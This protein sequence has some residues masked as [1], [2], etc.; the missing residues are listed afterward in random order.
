MFRRFHNVNMERLLIELL[1]NI[2][3]SLCRYGK[4]WEFED[5][6]E[7]RKP[8]ASHLTASAVKDIMSFRLVSVTFQHMS[9]PHFAKVITNTTFGMKRL[10]HLS[11]FAQ[12]R[13]G[14]MMR[15]LTL[16][17]DIYSLGF[18]PTNYNDPRGN[19]SDRCDCETCVQSGPDKITAQLSDVLRNLTR[20]EAIFVGQWLGNTLFRRLRQ[21]AAL[22]CFYGALGSAPSILKTLVLPTAVSF[23]YNYFAAN[24][25]PFV[26]LP[27]S[28]L[29]NVT[30]LEMASSCDIDCCDDDPRLCD[31]LHIFPR[32]STLSLRLPL[33]L[34][35]M[36]KQLR[37][38]T[39]RP[40][41]HLRKLKISLQ[42]MQEDCDDWTLE[43]L[44]D[45]LHAHAST[46]KSLQIGWTS[47]SWQD[48]ELELKIIKEIERTL[49]LSFL[50]VIWR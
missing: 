24:I 25:A 34:H 2:C 40:I 35:V 26:V 22:I 38:L 42:N 37:D 4:P 46:L 15:V 13:F 14:P 49:D 9:E 47:G 1:N 32:L 36:R 28:P 30:F 18:C 41:L 6:V 48:V 31:Y 19:V 3:G 43:A 23:L 12:S 20:L 50:S 10:E 8:C 21:R 29:P 7:G 17:D 5:D 27:P 45:F 33:S 16:S 39:A 44:F 11:H